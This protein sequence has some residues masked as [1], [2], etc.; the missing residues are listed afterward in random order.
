M[1]ELPGAASVVAAGMFKHRQFSGVLFALERTGL[2]F[3]LAALLLPG[4]TGI[5][6]E[7][8]NALKDIYSARVNALRLHYS[9]QTLLQADM[10]A[11]ALDPTGQIRNRILNDLI[12]LIDN[13]YTF[14]EKHLYNKK[15]FTDFGADVAVTSLSTLSGIVSGGGVQGA[16]SI[17]AFVAGGITS[18]KASFNSDILQSQNLLAIVA[19][20]R[21]Q[22]AEKRIV[23]QT[24]MYLAD[25]TEARA[26]DKYSLDQGLIDLGNYYQAGTFVS[27]L[28]DIV[29]K[30]GKEKNESEAT[31][32]DLQ[33]VTDAKIR[34]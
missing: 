30:A 2:A 14:W 3:C 22:R 33:G 11:A 28:Q 9:D 34:K 25:G 7:S 24:G 21:A 29:D 6:F 20:M 19:K 16:K 15:S 23:L 32:K 12:F 8:G 10:R 1:E 31:L 26:L 17:L 27:A 4:C 5:T 18:T 13:N